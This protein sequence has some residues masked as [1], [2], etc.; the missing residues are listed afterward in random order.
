MCL[1]LC[2]ASLSRLVSRIIHELGSSV[3]VA[4]GLHMSLL[5]HREQLDESLGLNSGT[6]F[7]FV[8]FSVASWR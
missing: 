7:G 6:C 8:L 4:L 1:D 5:T 2:G 3:D